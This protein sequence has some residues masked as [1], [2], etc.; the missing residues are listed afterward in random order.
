MGFRRDR[1]FHDTHRFASIVELDDAIALRIVHHT[2][3]PEARAMARCSIGV[4][5]VP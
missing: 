3:Q 1:L 5:P 2:V 4:K